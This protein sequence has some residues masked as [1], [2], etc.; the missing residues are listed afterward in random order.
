MG[1]LGRTPVRVRPLLFY[2]CYHRHSTERQIMRTLILNLLALLL[3]PHAAAA[4]DSRD[5][6]ALVPGSHLAAHAQK[7]PKP[8]TFN[9]TELQKARLDS[10]RQKVWRWQDKMQEALQ[11]F[12]AICSEAQKDNQWPAVQCNLND[13]SVA[14]A[15]PSSDATIVAAPMA[16]T[17]PKEEPKK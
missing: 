8:E 5:K 13:L 10:A 16:A 12:G 7:D 15:P 17:P 3:I 2:C 11:E 14:V 9:L 4:Q 1:F 6:P